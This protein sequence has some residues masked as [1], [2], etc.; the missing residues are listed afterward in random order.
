MQN[1]YKILSLSSLIL[2]TFYY[3]YDIPA[4]LNKHLLTGNLAQKISLLY[5]IY[6]LPNMILPLFI[7][8]STF[9]KISHLSMIL[10]TLVFFGNLLFS[11]GVYIKSYNLMLIGRL[12]YGIGGESFAVIQNMIIA[13][14]FRGRELAFSMGLSSSIARCGTVFNYL[15][16]PFLAN[17]FGG[18]SSC[19]LGCFLT[20]IGF[21]ACCYMNK[22]KAPMC[23]HEKLSKL[24]TRYNKNLHN[25]NKIEYIE[26]NTFKESDFN[27]Y[28]QENKA[29]FFVNNSKRSKHKEIKQEDVKDNTEEILDDAKIVKTQQK[30]IEDDAILINHVE[31]K[32]NFE[33]S[34]PMGTVINTNEYEYP[35]ESLTGNV[36]NEISDE[37]RYK[38]PFDSKDLDERDYR[39]FYKN[40]SVL[41]QQIMRPNPA[42][43]INEPVPQ[44]EKRTFSPGFGLLVAISFMFAVIWAPFSSLATTML[45]K[46]YGI[47]SLSAGRL[48]A[49]EE[50]LSLIFTL[51]ISTISD[52]FGY[53]LFFVGIGS[54]LLTIAHVLIFLIYG[55]PLV[56]IVI[57][58]FSGPFIACYWPCIT[59][60][61]S[62]ERVGAGFG[63]FTCV[64]NVAYTFAPVMIS[65][66]VMKDRNFDTVEFFM[67]C[68][69][70]LAFSFIVIL[71]YVNRKIRLNLN[72][73]SFVAM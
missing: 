31:F 14:E 48:M 66:L 62:H 53:K 57:I 19:I 17:H 5:S 26:Y 30:I 18:I 6:A 21:I 10:C 70:V 42:F 22:K 37:I 9:I 73:K 68:V 59:Y 45:Q 41:S 69:S 4:A 44:D 71:Q 39:Y 52:F 27:D 16:T 36:W 23:I 25:D 34:S 20:L 2:F 33:N 46:R 12:V 47:S 60:L 7:G 55:S 13:R 61:V 72:R 56:P 49:V 8:F 3:V 58:G 28:Y 63:I 65:V 15:I 24:R 40:E 50:G 43:E 67:I 11:L 54:V 38:K 29:N 32:H 51:C 64:L 1:R 35:P